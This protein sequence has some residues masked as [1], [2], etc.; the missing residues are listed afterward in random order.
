M[1]VNKMWLD[2]KPNQNPLGTTR[3]NRNIIVNKELGSIINE[4]GNLKVGT[5]GDNKKVIGVIVLDNN[6]F[7]VFTKRAENSSEIGYVDKNLIYTLLISNG[8][9]DFSVNRPIHGEFQR[10]NKNELIVI[11]TDG[12]KLRYF[13]KD[14]PI[15]IES[16]NVFPEIINPHIESNVE[17]GGGLK[18]GTYYPIVQYER[19]DLTTFSW[20]KHYNPVFIV[21]DAPDYPALA[22][23]DVRQGSIP[24]TPTDKQ[25]R[26]TIF[27]IDS[28][29]KRL[30]IGVVYLANN[31]KTYYYIKSFNITGVSGINA[32]ITDLD[33]ATIL[34]SDEV[35]I[36][37]SK[38]K[39]VKHITQL[40]NTLYLAD[41]ENFN[42]PNQQEVIN[43]IKL[44]FKSSLSNFLGGDKNSRDHYINNQKRHFQHGECYAVYIRLCYRW[45]YGKWWHVPGR[46]AFAGD[47]DSLDGYKKYQ[48][49]DTCNTSGELSYWENE[50]E[51]YPSTG[52]YPTGNVRHIK[53]PSIRWMKQNVY[54][55]DPEY[56]GRKLDL[57]NLEISNIDLNL[58]DDGEGNPPFEYQIGYAKRDSTNGL[59]VGQSIFVGSNSQQTIN[60]YPVPY[61]SLGVNVNFTDPTWNLSRVNIRTYD[62]ESLFKKQSPSVNFIR[63]EVI[64]TGDFRVY[65]KPDI[66]EPNKIDNMHVAVVNFAADNNVV[67]SPDSDHIKVRNSKYI[68]NNTI[69]GNVNNAYLEDTV[70][71]ELE[72]PLSIAVPS[73]NEFWAPSSTFIPIETQLIT[74]L[75]IKR[76]CYSEFF[77][78]SIVISER[79][80]ITGFYGGDTYVNLTNIITFGNVPWLDSKYSSDINESGSHNTVINGLRVSNYFVHESRFNSGFRYVNDGALGGNTKFAYHDDP[81]VFLPTLKRDQEPN[82]ITQ[83]Y[84]TDYNAQNDLTFSDIFN[85]NSEIITR[86]KFKVTRSSPISNESNI[87]S[88]LNFKVNDIYYLNKTKGDLVF[89]GA[90]KDYLILHHKNALFRTR[91]RTYI[92]TTGDQ[93]FTGQGDIFTNDPEEVLF[94]KVGALGT[95]HRWSCYVSKWG[96]FWIDSEAKKVYRYDDQVSDLSA[97]GLNNFFLKNS[98]CVDDNPFNGFGFHLVIDE[99]NKRLLLSKKHLKLKPEYEKSFKG[100]WKDEEN[101][102]NSL[103]KGDIIIKDNN[104]V[105]V[106]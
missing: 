58:L 60:N 17:T 78:Q 19:E 63:P 86:D 105:V 42:E 99:N 7:I 102:L 57:L 25:I 22:A 67:I 24:N 74:L 30:R 26:L 70:N 61:R 10:N 27:N 12:T 77:N 18:A 16:I 44:K 47:L 95:Q 80:P 76:S 69:S 55:S 2:G 36:D 15:S 65:D 23:N 46:T 41:L 48:L 103:A 34:Q 93:A 62:F 89:L 38:Y 32:V 3:A 98:V 50:D 104:Y 54:N 96:Y 94:D 20:I 51:Q 33:Q 92:D 4:E 66:P 68:L 73:R 39:A 45:G 81:F 82:L 106:Q 79:D 101:F 37:R 84:S 71:L 53:F 75:N 91:T 43:N 5:Y 14:L 1:K 6:D 11:F 9:L 83:G 29:F 100:I 97:N 88:W 21:A 13:N 64:L 49:T 90:G 85:P 52:Y 31:I 8:Q 35:L 28:R 40:D 72:T 87:N 56:G 59:I